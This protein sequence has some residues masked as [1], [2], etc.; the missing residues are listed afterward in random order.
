MA[1]EGRYTI[2]ELADLA[3]VTPRTVRYYVAQGLLARPIGAGPRARY[4]ADHLRRLR[5]IRRLQAEHQ[6]LATIR[7]H[8]GS[9]T[10]EEVEAAVTHAPEAAPDSAIEY[11]DHVLGGH[12]VR[13]SSTLVA[14]AAQPASMQ[15]GRVA[16][17]TPAGAP[18]AER[19]QWDRIQLDPDVEL[20]VRRPLSRNQSK[21]VER[22]VE[23]ARQILEEEPT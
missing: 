22:L 9:M 11:L 17:S 20:H 19:S 10:V 21:R 1:A 6:P 14:I 2:G 16:F 5:L 8:L 3:D 4:D 12:S 7:R 15:V 23:L 13:E 18:T